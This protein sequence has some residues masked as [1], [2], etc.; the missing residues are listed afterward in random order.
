MDEQK[1]TAVQTPAKIR[2]KSLGEEFR[3]T[4]LKSDVKDVRSYVK[5]EIIVPTIIRGFYDAVTGGLAMLLGLDVKKGEKS[6]PAARVSYRR[7]YDE[8][9]SGS[10]APVRAQ[11]SYSVMNVHYSS[12]EDAENVLRLMREVIDDSRAVSVANYLDFSGLSGMIRFTDSDWGWT[13]LNGVTTVRVDDEEAP[14]KL[15]LPQAKSLKGF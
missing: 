8:R 3:E 1:K 7:Y 6:V 15:D 14:W 5:R 13:N 4:F 9:N 12:K 2:K 11:T 10:S